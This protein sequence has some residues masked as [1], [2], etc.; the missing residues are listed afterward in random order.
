MFSRFGRNSAE[1]TGI[2]SNPG[3]AKL[4]DVEQNPANSE[5]YICGWELWVPIAGPGQSIGS[6]IALS[7]GAPSRIG[8]HVDGAIDE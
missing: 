8:S 7:R 1:T 5:G 4:A 2:R 6:P 3:Q